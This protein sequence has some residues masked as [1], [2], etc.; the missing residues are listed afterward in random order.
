MRVVVGQNRNNSGSRALVD[1]P[2]LPA[3]AALRAVRQWRYEPTIL[4]G[5]AIEVEQDITVVFSNRERSF[6]SRLGKFA[7]C[8]GRST[9]QGADGLTGGCF[10][11]AMIAAAT[12]AAIPPPARP[13]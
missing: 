8:V 3:E 10:S 4:G 7:R 13:A 11:E 6:Y 2:A 9:V 1:G 5:A 12:P